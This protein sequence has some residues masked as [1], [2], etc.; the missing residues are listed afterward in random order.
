MKKKVIM[1]VIIIILI[2]PLFMFNNTNASNKEIINKD[3]ISNKK[4]I[5]YPVKSDNINNY[6]KEKEKEEIKEKIVIEKRKVREVSKKEKFKYITTKYDNINK[7]IKEEEKEEEEIKY[8]CIKEET[9]EEKRAI[10]ISSW[11][12]TIDFEKVKNSNLV[13]YIIVRIGYGTTLNDEPVLDSQ[14]KRN[15]IELKKYNIPY[16][17]YLFG[18]AQNLNASNIEVNFIDNMLKKYNIPKD[19]FIWYDAELTT[20]NGFYYSKTIYNMVIDNFVFGLNNL[21]YKNVGVYGNLYMLTK[22]SLSYEKKYP[23]WVAQY[24]DKCDYEGEYKGWQYTSDG[25][26]DGIDGRVDMNIFY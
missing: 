16:G 22:G 20:F 14:F 11:Q 13:D 7:Y 12:G 26:I 5:S 1:I 8:V 25:H 24:N 2:I 18:Y 3:N 17:I 10:D 4:K 9:V 6:I 19:T 21:G 23:V 15:I